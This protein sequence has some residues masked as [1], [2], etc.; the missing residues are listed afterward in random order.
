MNIN[1]FFDRTHKMEF[2][3]KEKNQ[4]HFLLTFSLYLKSIYYLL[5][6]IKHLQRQYAFN[7]ILYG[8][9]RR[10]HWPI[11]NV[12]LSFGENK[13]INKLNKKDDVK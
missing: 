13:I 4:S 9:G 10:K 12:R 3:V 8:I 11:F 2:R 1:K 5:R 7:S 6:N